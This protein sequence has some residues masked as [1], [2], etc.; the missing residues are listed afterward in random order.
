MFYSYT[1]YWSK[2]LISNELVTQSLPY[3]YQSIMHFNPY[4]Y[5][6]N[7]MYTIETK[8]S[9]IS[10]LALGSAE[11][12]TELDYTHLQLLYCDGMLS[13]LVVW[14]LLRSLVLC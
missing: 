12:P 2:F 6:K 13:L 1:A 5:S 9:F 14:L 11:V 8:S 10:V 3:D 7:D 4:A